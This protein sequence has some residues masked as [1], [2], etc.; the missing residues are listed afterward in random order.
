MMKLIVAQIEI[1]VM[2]NFG[3]Y[4]RYGQYSWQKPLTEFVSVVSI[5]DAQYRNNPLTL[6]HRNFTI[7]F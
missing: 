7:K 5:I 4:R 6:W 2:D 3:H 1:P